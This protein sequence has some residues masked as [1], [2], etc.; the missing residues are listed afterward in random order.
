MFFCFVFKLKN[1]VG[2]HVNVSLL[3]DIEASKNTSTSNTTKDIGTSTVEEG[4]NTLS[5]EDSGETVQRT[6]VLDSLTGGHHHTTT[7]SINRVRDNTG[8][9]GNSVTEHEVGKSR[10]VLTEDN[11][12]EGIVET[13]V[14]TTVHNNTNARNNETTVESGN[15]IGSDGLLVNIHETGVLTRTSLLGRLDIV[16]KTSSGVIQ[17]VN[18]G[19][20]DGT[21]DTTGSDVLGEL[22]DESIILAL[23][24]QSLDLIL[25][26]EVQSLGREVT[27][28]VDSV[29]SPQGRDTLGSDGALSAVND[30]VVRSVQSSRLD[31]LTLVLDQKLDT[32]DRGG[33]G[34]GNHSSG[35]RETEVLD[36]AQ[37]VVLSH[38]YYLDLS[39]KY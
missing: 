13:E 39:L 21:G 23:L 19:K 8:S 31:H 35:T 18:E 27:K 12:L 9:D 20:G 7:D 6:V 10:R 32:L 29:T 16:T 28:T 36:E 37:L 24:E 33:D 17:R 1:L 2:S 3:D 38:C 15:T 26:G 4:H 22:G 30:T 34:L 11:R 25:E 5:L 14:T